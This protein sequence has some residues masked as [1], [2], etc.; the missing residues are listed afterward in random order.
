M[1]VSQ[2]ALHIIIGLVLLLALSSLVHLLYTSQQLT[3]AL[4]SVQAVRRDL[5]VAQDSLS[6]VRHELNT[7]ATQ[8]QQR[9]TTLQAIREQVSRIDKQYQADQ[10]HTQQ[11]TQALKVRSKEKEIALRQLRKEA[12]KFSQP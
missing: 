12:Q 9:E 4:Q 11:R 10:A 2:K 7:L 5:S 3:S 6:R 8:L 1:F